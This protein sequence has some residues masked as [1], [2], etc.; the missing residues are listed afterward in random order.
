MS[1]DTRA[2][3]L[4][5]FHR[6]SAADGNLLSQ[7]MAESSGDA[8]ETNTPKA[9]AAPTASLSSKQQRIKAYIKNEAAAAGAD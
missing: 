2:D 1:D 3:H 5:N 4:Q 6:S 7:S 9:M 8:K